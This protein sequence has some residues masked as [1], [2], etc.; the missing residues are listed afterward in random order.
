M[1]D[2]GRLT[3][4][5]RAIDDGIELKVEDDGAGMEPGEVERIFDHFYTTK[6]RGT[7]LGLPN[8][9]DIIALHG[10]RLTCRSQEGEGTT[11]TIW[12]P[13]YSGNADL[14]DDGKEENEGEKDETI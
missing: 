2:G 3:I 6:E 10:G 7:G 8:A 4:R 13:A 9:Q 5:S 12:L 14:L 1:E 11:F